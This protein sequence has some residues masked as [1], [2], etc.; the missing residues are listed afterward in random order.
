M[1]ESEMKNA[2]PQRH[3]DGFGPVVDLEFLQ[4]VLDMHLHGVFS[5]TEGR[6]N[7]RIGLAQRESSED[8]YIAFIPRSEEP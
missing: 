7:L 5:N 4:H 2:S 8:V 3:R 6:A 1:W